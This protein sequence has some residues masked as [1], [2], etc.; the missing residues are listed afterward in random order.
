MTQLNS[1]LDFRKH[2]KEVRKS[3]AMRGLTIQ[4]SAKIV[5]K[6]LNSDEFKKAK[7]IAIYYP[8]NGEIDLL[9][10]LTVQDKEF[11]F[12]RTNNLDLEFVK[13]NKACDLIDGTFG[14]KVPQGEAINPDILDIVYLPALLAN[15]NNFR[16]G[17]GKGYYDRFLAKNAVHALKVIVVANELISDD[18]IQD[19][20]DYKCHKIISA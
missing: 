17:Y 2:A 1:K 18:F 7:N 9:G 13:Y 5:S 11:Y 20:F 16:L 8:I 14:E 4:K 12:P 10:L 15:K 3:L 6:I 19:E